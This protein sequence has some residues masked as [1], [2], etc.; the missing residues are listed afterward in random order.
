M[1]YPA[2][3]SPIP[4]HY[5]LPHYHDERVES[6][7]EHERS[8]PQLTF[9]QS[10]PHPLQLLP[11][12]RSELSP[13]APPLPSLLRPCATLPL[14]TVNRLTQDQR[15]ALRAAQHHFLFLGLW[16]YRLHLP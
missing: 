14:E 13:I 3:A 12:S 2:I 10:S 5:S 11:S 7:A 9:G 8:G 6:L 15:A 16:P 1:I 4:L